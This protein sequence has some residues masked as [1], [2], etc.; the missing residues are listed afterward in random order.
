MGVGAAKLLSKVRKGL[1][2]SG[3]EMAG[4]ERERGRVELLAWSFRSLTVARSQKFILRR[5]VKPLHLQ[6]Q[7]HPMTELLPRAD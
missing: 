1:E 5:R 7:K 2:H 4:R 3:E 6:Q